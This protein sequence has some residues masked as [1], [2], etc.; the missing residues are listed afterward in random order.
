MRI[1]ARRLPV[2][3][4]FITFGAVG[5]SGVVIDTLALVA[6][7]EGFGADP[8]AAACVAFTFAVTWNF[9]LNRRWT[10]RADGGHLLRQYR[11][12]VA[13]CLLGL[14]I[15]LATMHVLIEWA[16]MGESPLYVIASFI[17]MGAAT[18]W[19]FLGSKYVAFADR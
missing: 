9:L 3:R 4:Q 7:V 17:G 15:R 14:G 19:N 10:F 13:T 8:R 5:A 12:F 18:L 11:A 2:I 16:G 6:V 1:S